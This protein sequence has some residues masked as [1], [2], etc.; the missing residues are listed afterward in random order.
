MWKALISIAF[1]LTVSLGAPATSACADSAAGWT[2]ATVAWQ[3]A[4]PDGTRFALLE[5]RRDLPGVAFSYAF[6]IPAGVWDGPHRHSA[7]ARVFVAK[8]AL[9]IGYGSRIDKRTSTTYPAGS[10]AIVPAGAVHFDG[11]DKD[12]VIIGTAIG[13]WSTTYLDGS[14]PASAGTPLPRRGSR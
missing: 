14:A 6:S 9:K 8:G 13:P 3:R 10:Y 11:A 7:T 2:A 12:T 5:G 4:A 1:I